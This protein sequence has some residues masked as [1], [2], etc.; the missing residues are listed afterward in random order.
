[1]SNK[2]FIFEN[3]R[4]HSLF[5]YLQCDYVSNKIVGERYSLVFTYKE[6]DPAGKGEENKNERRFA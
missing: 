5:F 4:Y 2:A 3:A 1:M 6:F